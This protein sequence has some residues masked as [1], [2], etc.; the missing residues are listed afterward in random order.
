MSA[1]RNGER[2]STTPM[3]I[4]L[5]LMLMLL[6]TVVDAASRLFLAERTLAA[7]ADGAAVAAADA[8]DEPAYYRTDTHSVVPL[9]RSRVEEVVREY[10]ERTRLADRWPEF[11]LV[12]T[13]DDDATTV[14]VVGVARVRVPLVDA[15][16]G[17]QGG[18]GYVVSA[19]ASARTPLEP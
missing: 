1:T 2:G 19:S 5:A 7:T 15:V 16:T 11:E 13:L 14:T 10:A 3:L 4:G 12:P 9:R 8:L 6:V 18:S 17:G